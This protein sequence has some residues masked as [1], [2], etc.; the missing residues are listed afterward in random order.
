MS[1][2]LRSQT[3]LRQTLLRYIHALERGDLNTITTILRS[4]ERD[5]LLEQR[6]LEIGRFYQMQDSM[7]VHRDELAEAH[8]FLASLHQTNSGI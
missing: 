7:T 2:R 5:P 4:A 6:I 1:E 8:R 3:Q